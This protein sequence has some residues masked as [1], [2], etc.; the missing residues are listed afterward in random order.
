MKWLLQSEDTI[1]SSWLKACVDTECPTCH[2]P[3]ANGY[4]D[5]NECTRRIC[6]N[7]E[8]PRTIAARIADMCV[9]LGIDGIKEGMGYKLVKDHKL[10]NWFDAIPKICIEKPKITLAMLFKLSFIFGMNEEFDTLCDECTTVEQ[11]INKY[12]GVNEKELKSKQELLEYGFTKFEIIQPHKVDK[13]FSPVIGGLVVIT[14]EVPGYDNRD[15]FIPIVN[16]MFLGLTNFTYAKNRRKTGLFCCISQ[17]KSASTGKVEDAR[18]SNKPIYTKN[19]FMA[20]I[21]NKIKEAGKF[22]EYIK[23]YNERGETK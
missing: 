19:E 20:V 7:A 14:G 11:A 4:N 16:A 10:T 23:V 2:S 22:E 9:L 21:I 17:D 13:V 15:N 3:I 12:H 6:T 1:M 8:C 5:K 18:D